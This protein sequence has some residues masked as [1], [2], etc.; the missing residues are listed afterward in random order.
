MSAV[1]LLVCGQKYLWRHAK[2]TVEH[3][4]HTTC[5]SRIYWLASSWPFFV[6]MVGDRRIKVI[7]ATEYGLRCRTV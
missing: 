6:D 5:V 1:G 2:R 4:E 7:V 3:L